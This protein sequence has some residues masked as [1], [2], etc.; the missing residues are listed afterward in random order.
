[1]TKELPLTLDWQQV[2]DHLEYFKIDH[3]GKNKT[4][5]FNRLIKQGVTTHNVNIIIAGMLV[6]PV[7]TVALAK[8]DR[9][10]ETAQQTLREHPAEA[11]AL[12]KLAGQRDSVIRT[13]SNLPKIPS[14]AKKLSSGKDL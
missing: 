11:A 6:N 1:M 12:K 13:N 9:L 8:G 7:L 10:P 3:D 5:M 2:K 14:T 4:G